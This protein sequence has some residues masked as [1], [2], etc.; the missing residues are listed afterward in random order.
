MRLGT[1]WLDFVPYNVPP[2]G[3]S[4]EFRN[5]LGYETLCPLGGTVG[6]AACMTGV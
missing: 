5:V 1:A 4:V 2:R 6:N 3:R